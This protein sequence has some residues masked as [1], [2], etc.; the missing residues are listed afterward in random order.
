MRVRNLATAVL[1]GLVMLFGL[2]VGLRPVEA[3]VRIHV[4]L[5]SQ[6][7]QVRSDSGASYVWPVSTARRGF[8]TPRGSYGVQSLQRMHVSH[9]YH[10]S[11]MPH[12]IFFRGGY[13]IHGT[14][15]VGALG[16]AASHGCIRLAPGNAALLYQMVRAEGARISITGSAPADVR[17]AGAEY[18]HHHGD[19]LAYAAHHHHGHAQVAARRIPVD[20]VAYAPLAPSYDDWMDDPLGGSGY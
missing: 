11:P 6:T 1:S 15:S 13:A 3:T 8:V 18:R 16:R 4:D 10:N 20:P 9:K 7:M 5:T 17:Y 19:R 2:G 12:S 14:Y